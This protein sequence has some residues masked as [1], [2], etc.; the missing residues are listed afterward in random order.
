MKNR[1]IYINTKKD[2]ILKII[3]ENEFNILKLLQKLNIEGAISGT[4]LLRRSYTRTE[5]K[6]EKKNEN[7]IEIE[8]LF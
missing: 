7:E 1:K 2:K 5:E 6:M 8:K 3:D 4:L